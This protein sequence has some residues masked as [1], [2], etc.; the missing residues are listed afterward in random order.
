MNF[1]V[2]TRTKAE[3]ERLAA[4]LFPGEAIALARLKPDTTYPR[5]QLAHDMASTLHEIF[6]WLYEQKP[7]IY[8][9][10]RWHL[11]YDLAHRLARQLDENGQA[12]TRDIYAETRNGEWQKHRAAQIMTGDGEGI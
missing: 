4:E 7:R 10:A 2:L 6:R 3:A 11:F 12:K 5:Y 8:K 9:R 1:P